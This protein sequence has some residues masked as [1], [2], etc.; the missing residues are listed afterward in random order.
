MEEEGTL[1]DKPVFPD[2]RDPLGAAG[3][4]GAEVADDPYLVLER[5]V[6]LTEEQQVTRGEHF[7]E[8]PLLRRVEG[9]AQIELEDG[10]E[11]RRQVSHLHRD[12][13]IVC[14]GY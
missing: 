14:A 1:G 6:L 12:P 8:L 9:V 13:P 5:D 10:A 7:S 2:V 4:D 11:R 3:E